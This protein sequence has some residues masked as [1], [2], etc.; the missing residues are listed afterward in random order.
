M[1]DCEKSLVKM[2]FSDFPDAGQVC[3]DMPLQ[4]SFI[5]AVQG[6]IVTEGIPFC[7]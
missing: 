6:E 1:P 4:M 7:V 2:K 5:P 3:A